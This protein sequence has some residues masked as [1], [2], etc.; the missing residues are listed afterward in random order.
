MIYLTFSCYDLSHICQRK[1]CQKYKNVPP[2]RKGKL[3]RNHDGFGGDDGCANIMMID[4]ADQNLSSAGEGC[5]MEGNIGENE[6]RVAV[7]GKLLQS[8]H[9]VRTRERQVDQEAEISRL[10]L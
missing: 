2:V 10:I 3:T 6:E 7:L 9:V 4:N 8:R 1:K 5:D